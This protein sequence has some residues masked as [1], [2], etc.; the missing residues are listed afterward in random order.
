MADPN[1]E[2]TEYDQWIA[3]GRSKTAGVLFAVEFDRRHRQRGVRA[4]AVHPGAVQ[5]ELQRHY[6]ADEDA[7]LIASINKA[8]AA[9][10][11]PPFRWKTIP[12]GA[13]TS[14]WAAAVAPADAVG[15]HYCED[16][17]VAEINDRKGLRGGV[18][19]YAVDPERARALWAKAEEMVNERF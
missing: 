16:C 17:H 1:F 4:T 18:R 15:G 11:L 7:A 5:T 10:G 8:N 12:Q 9:A 19:S 3:Y 14:V 13:A 2:K 6:T